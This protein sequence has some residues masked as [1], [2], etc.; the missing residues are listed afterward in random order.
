MEISENLHRADLDVKQR[1][2]Q[3]AQWIRLTEETGTE[4]TQLVQVGPAVLSDGRRKGPQHKES[5][6]RKA[7]RELGL[8]H[9]SVARATKVAALDPAE[10][11]TARLTHSA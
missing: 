6:T 8:A 5:G 3:V 1:S 2:D 4:S 10:E 7:E 9:T 11:E